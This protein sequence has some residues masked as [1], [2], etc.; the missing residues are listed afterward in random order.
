VRSDGISAQADAGQPSGPSTGLVACLTTGLPAA[1]RTLFGAKSFHRPALLVLFALPQMMRYG[2]V[3]MRSRW[4]SGGS[5]VVA[6]LCASGVVASAAEPN[7][8][9]I[10][11]GDHDTVDAIMQGL[12]G[13]G[14]AAL[15]VLTPK[16]GKLIRAGAAAGVTSAVWN[17]AKSYFGSGNDVQVCV[18][19]E[20]RLGGL[21]LLGPH[22][23]SLRPSDPAPM[24]V[25][26]GPPSITERLMNNEAANKIA[27]TRL[28][29]LKFGEEFDFRNFDMKP[30]ILPSEVP[31]FG[32]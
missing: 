32:R 10:H 12:G 19:P 27:D 20:P 18:T 4:I 7:C 30:I 17:A 5:A 11:R 8:S 28:P 16:G 9:V 26:V 6:A 29:R 2:G 23:G 22:L 31:Q 13:A 14:A 25:Y 24:R 3:N 15:L 1:K 21:D